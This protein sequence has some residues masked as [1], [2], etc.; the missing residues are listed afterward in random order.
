MLKQFQIPTAPFYMVPYDSLDANYP[1]LP[2]DLASYPLFAKLATEGSSKGIDNFNKVNHPTELE[3]TLN[4]LRKRYPVQPII[5]ESFLSGREFSVCILGTGK[6]SRVIG[7]REHIWG[8]APK[9]SE[10][11]RTICPCRLDFANRETKS[12]TSGNGTRLVVC[13]YEMG[14]VEDPQID[15]ACKVALDAWKI[16]LCRDAGRVD[17]RFDCDDPNGVPNILEVSHCHLSNLFASGHRADVLK[18][19][20]NPISGLLPC[21]SPLTVCAEKNGITFERLLSSI[22]RSALQRKN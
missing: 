5:L 14:A 1:A 19:Q 2:T 11:N 4:E 10:S 12:N 7:I 3:G 16:L 15:A 21:H 6:H 9:D 13:D 20:V 22:I 17:I 18:Q 8:E